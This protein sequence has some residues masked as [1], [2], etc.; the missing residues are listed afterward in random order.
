MNDPHNLH[1]GAA[2]PAE[3]AR[4][5]ALAG[6][7]WDPKGPMRPLHAMNPVRV[8]WIT[9]RLPGPGT[10]LDVGC[11]AG[12]AAEALAR[13][14]HDV[15]GIDAA[16]EA[17]A[18]ARLHAGSLGI[19]YREALTGELVAEGRRFAAVTALEVI[20]HVPDPAGFMR[21]LAALVAPGG[22]VFVSTLNRT[23]RSL[24]V[25]KLGAEYLL[26]LLPVGTHDWRRFVTPPELAR[27]GRGAG[28]RMV[29]SAGMS[30]DP[31]AG[32][33]RIGRDLGINYI[34]AFGR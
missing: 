4:F 17:I 2:S 33:W 30:F 5:D 22:R 28:L 1:G 15:T 27:L 13:A 23:V 31:L 10:L 24:A 26:R 20:E 7:W 12:L 14:G 16:G 21:D 11:G 25:A 32:R 18:A 6:R 9:A 19:V 29:D 3:V 34:A 8:G